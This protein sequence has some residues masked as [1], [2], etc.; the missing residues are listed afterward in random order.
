[1]LDTATSHCH[2][3]GEVVRCKQGSVRFQHQAPVGWS[4]LHA[5]SGH[6]AG[7][8]FVLQLIR[9]VAAKHQLLAARLLWQLHNVIFYGLIHP[10]RT[11][12]LSVQSPELKYMCKAAWQ[13]HPTHLCHGV[14]FSCAC[15]LL[16]RPDQRCAAALGI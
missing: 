8:P 13:L 12:R 16:H 15:M 9:C 6:A 7:T 5:H 10:S 2:V 1:M 4:D 11:P 3:R 14:P